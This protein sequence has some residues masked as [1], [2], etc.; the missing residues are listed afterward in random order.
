MTTK[1]AFT[2]PAEAVEGASEVILLGDFNNWN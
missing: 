1:I 2:L